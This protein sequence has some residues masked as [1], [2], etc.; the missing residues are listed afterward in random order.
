MSYEVLDSSNIIG[1][2]KQLKPKYLFLDVFDTLIFRKNHPEDVKKLAAQLL[3][4]RL[5]LDLNWEDLYSFRNISEAELC[6]QNQKAGHDLE[7]HFEQLIERIYCY[8]AKKVERLDLLVNSSGFT[9]L[10]LDCELQAEKSTQYSDPNILELITECGAAGIKIYFVSDIYFSKYM[11]ETVLG[12][13]VKDLSSI[14]V[15]VSS[16]Y[17]RTKRTGNLYSL[18]LGSEGIDS[19]EIVMVGDNKESD[20]NQALKKDIKALHLD[21]RQQ[22]NFY[23]GQ[24]KKFGQPN[25]I[26]RELDTLFSDSRH[27]LFP[28]F[29]LTLY[30]FIS[31]LYYQL[32]N[33]CIKEVLFL[34]RE[35]YFLKILF[36]QFQ[37]THAFQNINTHYFKVSRRSTCIASLNNLAIEHFNS[38]LN[39]Y[40]FTSID[41]FLKTLSFEEEERNLIA[42]NLNIYTKARNKNLRSNI[43]FNRLI[44]LDAF[45]NLYE[46][47]R[48]KQKRLFQNYLDTMQLSD[49]KSLTMIDVGWKGTIQDHIY[50]ILD[51]QYICNG[52]Y[53]GYIQTSRN[54]NTLRNNKT[55]LLFSR[56]QGSFSKYYPLYSNNLPIFEILLSANHGAVERYEEKDGKVFTVEFW[57][58]E[59]EAL[60]RDTIAPIQDNFLVLIEQ[61]SK[62]LSNVPVSENYL[63]YIT[64]KYHRRLIE[65]PTTAEKEFF[66]Q[67]WHTENF[68]V[69]EKTTFRNPYYFNNFKKIARDFY[70]CLLKLKGY[71]IK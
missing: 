61:I 62:I 45:R 69:F 52:Y 9:N 49:A 14:T 59:D 1:V 50:K 40:A 6:R 37:K 16:E 47:K 51:H 42:A 23:S 7:F 43:S 4:N 27:T 24:S 60:Y 48:I 22:Y 8:L 11:L 46:E 18:I 41:E 38:I 19:A 58:K 28:E 57:S 55:G 66:K 68:G 2:I 67:I 25:H 17:L 53:A 31:K 20:Y 32:S 26:E 35:G 54:S 13:H 64:A 10:M 63:D 21:R 34:S 3:V 39:Q 36:D 65:A 71:L 70:Y 15:Y 30:S 33:N 56:Y 5:K 44:N 12:W 29:A